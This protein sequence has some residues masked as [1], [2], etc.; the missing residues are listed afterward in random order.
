MH[1]CCLFTGCTCFRSLFH[2][3]L[4]RR[5]PEAPLPQAPL[6]Q[7]LAEISGACRNAAA[8]SSPPSGLQELKLRLTGETCLGPVCK[9]GWRAG[10]RGPCQ[11][12][13]AFAFLPAG[14]GRREKKHTP[15]PHT[16]TPSSPS[17][18]GIPSAVAVQERKGKTQKKPQTRA[19][20]GSG[21]RAQPGGRCAGL[22]GLRAERTM[23][24]PRGEGGRQGGG[25][26]AVIPILF[27]ASL[28][29]GGSKILF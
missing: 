1:L 27:F 8:S 6:E 15:P 5:G 11:A 19:A 18:S 9:P 26:G 25:S 3:L 28:G 23:A 10:G 21:A 7:N 16:H 29:R 22:P 24:P 17:L 12:G 2:A 14:C 20:K 13:P 4:A